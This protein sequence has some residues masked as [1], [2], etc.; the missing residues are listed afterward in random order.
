MLK[1]LADKQVIQVRKARE[2]ALLALDIPPVHQKAFEMQK[3][4]YSIWY[5][6]CFSTGI[7]IHLPKLQMKSA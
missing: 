6:S 2:L 4:L 5:R 7:Q 3:P 1:S